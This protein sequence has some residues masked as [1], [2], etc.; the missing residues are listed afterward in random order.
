MKEKRFSERLLA[1]IDE[2]GTPACVGIDP[3]PDLIPQRFERRGSSDWRNAE[4]VRDFCSHAL[5]QIKHQVRIVKFQSA[6]FEVLGHQGIAI[7]EDLQ[8]EAE[9]LGMIT[10][11]DG[12]RGDIGDTSK[13]YAEA[14]LKNQG[15]DAMT[16]APYM[17]ADSVRAF[18]D[19][20]LLNGRGVFVLLRTSN[21]GALDI[22]RR[23]LRSDQ[24]VAE[25]VGDMVTEM[26][27]IYTA[28]YSD[29]GFVVGAT[30]NAYEMQKLRCQ[31]PTHWFLVPG[32]G[33]Q[34]GDLTAVQEAFNDDGH[35]AI[36]NSSRAILYPEEYG[37][38]GSVKIACNNFVLS[39]KGSK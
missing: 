29:V 1:A 21:K 7:L 37:G 22:Q 10:I 27:P 39:L 23:L 11:F 20:A 36:I 26:L 34:G 18:V 19:T 9:D 8:R 17:G 3:I 13:A 24:S 2:C 32:V 33:A 35:G 4:M 14:Y 16:V 30:A 31:Y 38:E 12:K 6:Y 28:E 25:R 5:N 15:Y